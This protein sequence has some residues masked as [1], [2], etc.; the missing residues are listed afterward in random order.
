MSAPKT[1]FLAELQR[2]HV[3]K[4]GAA[5]AVA[6][7]LLAQ[8]V[9][10]V[11]PVFGVS[12]LGQRIMVLILIGGFPVA[13]VLA[14]VF[15]LTPRGLVRTEALT[16]AGETPVLRGERRGMD[17]KLNLVLGGLLVLSLAY[18]VAERTVLKADG[19]AAAGAIGKSIAVLPFANTSGDAGNEY[20]SDGLSEELIGALGRLEHL[21]VIGRTSS[22]QFK[23]KTDDSKA[24]GEKL[25]VATLLEG[26]VRKQGERVRI[27]AELVN[28]A[29]GR[30]L[31]SETY[32]RE[33]KDIFAV[34]TEIAGAVA[35][36]LQVALLGNNAETVM[37]PT[38]TM[39]SNGS[40]EAYNA[41]LQ[42]QFYAA[43]YTAGDM[44]K[45]MS[46]YEQAT[47]LD[48]SYALAY[49]RLAGVTVARIS[50]Y[51]GDLSREERKR[52]D[53]QAR[54]AID[55]ALR[56]DPDLSAA[57]RAHASLLSDL[58]LDH[59]AAE[60]ELRRAAELAP[61]D[62]RVLG[63]LGWK[64]AE[65]GRP[66]E[67]LDLTRKAIALDPLF[68][69]VRQGLAGELMMLGRYDEAERAMRQAIELQPR[70][71]AVYTDLARVQV[72]QGHV[73]DALESARRETDPGLRDYALALV[74]FAKG[75][76]TEADAAL[77]ALIDRGDF[78]SAQ[79]AV[80]YAQRKQ[81]DKMFEW[82]E[83][84]WRVKDSGV[85]F[86]RTDPFVSAYRDDPRY[87]AFGR[88]IGVVA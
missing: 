1:S 55:T 80:V 70:A 84:G 45:A 47:R 9:T 10:Q 13:L 33:L 30:Q 41:L 46:Y 24:I 26:S 81:S 57:H 76:R 28:A 85:F 11:L 43:R 31:W 54:A 32:D 62:P 65:M 8:V 25:G 72:L 68:L 16:S 60:A 49:A 20:F 38:A 12:M 58:D 77:Q 3:Y 83:R 66:E 75:Q 56:L 29:D 35:R 48:P 4:V 23:N 15:D 42:G 73:D 18:V 86:L 34:Q 19:T 2:R 14:W 79:I 37:T 88:K 63:A 50:Y 74:W 59:P 40:I 53:A 6:G 71:A 82:L 52:L 21:K 87:L 17:R 69:L 51:G 7:W 5:Y 64:T 67:A 44:T 39:P 36:A 27:L 22:F 78:Y 61:Q